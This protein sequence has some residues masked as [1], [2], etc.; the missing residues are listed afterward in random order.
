MTSAQTLQLDLTPSDYI[1]YNI[2]CNGE[3][4]LPTMP[5]GMLYLDQSG[6][7]KTS[8]TGPTLGCASATLAVPVWTS[9]GSVGTIFTCPIYR[10]GIG[11]WNI[12]NHIK[13]KVEGQTWLTDKVGIGVD[14]LAINGPGDYLLV[15]NGKMGAKEIYC[16]AGTPWPDYVF[17]NDYPLMP[18]KEVKEYI[19]KHEHLPGIPSAEEVKNAG[20]NVYDQLAK[21]YEKIEE[22]YLHLI[23]LEERMKEMEKAK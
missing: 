10:V 9:E 11:T 18:L 13:L 4:A 14:P 17:S 2:A 6:K 16:S 8:N 12:P 7:I 3:I 1:G 19:T 20:I 23:R 22:L 21:A 5:G 15:V